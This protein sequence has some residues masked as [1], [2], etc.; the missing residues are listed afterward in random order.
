MDILTKGEFY[1]DNKNKS[2]LFPQ[3]IALKSGHSRGSTMD[4]TLVKVPVK[5]QGEYK[6]GQ[7]LERCDATIGVRFDDNS[8]DMT[9]PAAS[10]V[11]RSKPVI[12]LVCRTASKLSAKSC[13]AFSLTELVSW[14]MYFLKSPE[15]SVF[16]ATIPSLWQY[17][18]TCP[19]ASL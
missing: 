13:M 2:S 16:S 10:V 12:S 14:S 6:P 1:P 18:R 7:K 19:A 9:P 8:I 11:R 5:K 4:L 17:A 3:Y 15:I